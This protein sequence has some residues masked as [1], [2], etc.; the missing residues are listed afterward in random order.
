VAG[1]PQYKVNKTCEGE[2][3]MAPKR[4]HRRRRK[5]P[6]LRLDIEDVYNSV[7]R[8]AAAKNTQITHPGG[9]SPTR[10]DSS[11]AA[12][13]EGGVVVTPPNPGVIGPPGCGCGGASTWG[14]CLRQAMEFSLG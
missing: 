12:A 8:E 14:S 11:R 4:K 7:D 6:E 1:L 10:G 5:T 13:A 3:Q 9:P 2:W